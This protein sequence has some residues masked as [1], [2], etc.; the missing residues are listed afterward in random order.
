M[1]TLFIDE[2]G[3]NF[4][5]SIETNRPHFCLAGVILKNSDRIALKNR[6]DQI[7]FKYWGRT[8]IV[9]H[10]TDMINL[11]GAFSIFKKGTT[12]LSIT[13]FY[14][15]FINLIKE[16]DFKLSLFCLNRLNYISKNSLKKTVDKATS[17]DRVA[18]VQVKGTEVGIIDRYS[19]G[20]LTAY[21]YL[22]KNEKKVGQVVIEATGGPQDSYI[23][24]AYNRLL[25]SGYVGFKMNGEDI[26]NHYTS[27][28][29]VTKN[30]HDIETQLADC[31]S[32]FLNMCEREVDRIQIV[33]DPYHKDII[34]ALKSKS[35]QFSD[36]NGSPLKSSLQ[37][38]C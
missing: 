29:F 7:K 25:S 21:L 3:K 20:L 36:S 11:K 26:R 23:F 1:Y 5:R 24:K 2:S 9:F 34:A 33:A 6:A 31:A 22:L 28:A 15:D 38:E 4:L 35:F 12:K 13:D 32:S 10:T 27:I 30:N 18:E 8:D 16:S 14:E 37:R 19:S 17:G